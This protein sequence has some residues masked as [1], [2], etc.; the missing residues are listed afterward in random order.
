MKLGNSFSMEIERR[1]K[2][3]VIC[4]FLTLTVIHIRS[5]LPV[6]CIFFAVAVGINYYR[7]S[8]LKQHKFI[9]LEFYKPEVQNKFHLLKVKML[10][11]LIVPEAL[12]ENPFLCPF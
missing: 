10:A 9:L 4:R 5:S 1:K 11:R 2:S 6:W 7:F 8:G 12:E 3:V